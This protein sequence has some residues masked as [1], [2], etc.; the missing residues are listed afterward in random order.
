MGLFIAYLP[1]TCTFGR[2]LEID[3]RVNYHLIHFALKR[4]VHRKKMSCIAAS[5]QLKLSS[6]RLEFLQLSFC[7]FGS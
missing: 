5:A 4:I 7:S 3:N 2:K 6:L 1:K